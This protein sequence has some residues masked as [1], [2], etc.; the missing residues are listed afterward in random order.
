M[1]MKIGKKEIVRINKALGGHLSRDG[2]LEYALHRQNERKTGEFTK[3]AYLWRAILVD[4]PFTDASKRTAAY[5]AL[6]FAAQNKKVADKDLLMRHALSIAK[7][8]IT[9]IRKITRRLK[10]AIR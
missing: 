5:L 6:V 2:S 7:Q 1:C 3:L 10:N 9:S 4:H 8:N